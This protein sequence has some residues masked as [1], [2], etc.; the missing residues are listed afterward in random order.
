MKDWKG[1]R[2]KD[3]PKEI[4]VGDSIYRVRFVRAIGDAPKGS[5][6]ET[7]GLCCPGEKEILVKQGLGALER[8]STFVHELLHAVEFEYEIE[9]PHKLIYQ[10]ELPLTKLILDNN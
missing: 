5:E 7:L 10:L 4:V 8:F 9:I 3:Y 6:K 2:Q 1:P